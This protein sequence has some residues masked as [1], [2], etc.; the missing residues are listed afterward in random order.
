MFVLDE[1]DEML[2]RGF[3]DQIYDIFQK[4]NSNTQV[5]KT[6]MYS[7]A[8]VV[9]DLFIDCGVIEVREQQYQ[10]PEEPKKNSGVSGPAPWLSGSVHALH[11]IS[12]GFCWFRSLGPDVAPLIGP[13]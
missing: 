12:P 6:D 3:K 10:V 2:S 1:A 4:L 5:G 11:F 9:D 13:W 7:L 8:C